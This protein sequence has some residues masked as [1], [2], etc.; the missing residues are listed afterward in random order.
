MRLSAG[1]LIAWHG[2]RTA[3]RW[4]AARP[5]LLGSLWPRW[6]PSQSWIDGGFASEQPRL[7]APGVLN[8]LTGKLPILRLQLSSDKATAHLDCGIAFAADASERAKD[9]IP[10]VC[11]K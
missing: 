10:L 11:P 6:P 4:Q 9:Q 5:V 8:V 2:C 3:G 1:C 7:L